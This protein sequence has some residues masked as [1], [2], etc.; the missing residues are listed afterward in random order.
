MKFIHKVSW[1]WFCLV[2]RG[3]Y[4]RVGSLIRSMIGWQNSRHFLNQWEENPNQSWLARTRFP[5][6][7][8]GYIHSPRIL[9]GLLAFYV[10]CDWL[11]YPLW[12]LYM[13]RR[14]I[15][16]RSEWTE[17]VVIAKTLWNFCYVVNATRDC[18]W[19][20]DRRLNSPL[21]FSAMYFIYH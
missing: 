3:F 14:S 1:C 21:V 8:L 17:E 19:H 20:K 4:M 18:E 5:A 7:C 15:E 10:S 9:F 16:N 13:L 12:V 11:E 6:L 2:Q